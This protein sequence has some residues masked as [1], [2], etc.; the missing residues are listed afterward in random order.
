MRRIILAF[1]LVLTA[2]LP[3]RAQ[4]PN[5]ITTIAGGGVNG[6]NP[7]AAYLP[8]PFSTVRDSAGNTYISVPGLN[9]VY[10]VDATNKLTVFA[11]TGNSGFSGDG[12]A[13]TQ[14]QL[15]FPEGLAID[16]NN[17]LFIVDTNNNRIRRV[18]ATTGNITTVAGSEDPFN[19]NFGG[20]NGPATDARLNFPSGV[21]VDGNGDLFIT[22]TNNGAVRRVDGSTQIITTIAGGGAN[23]GCSG[24]AGNTA[25]FGDLIGIAV[26]GTGNV[27]VADAFLAIVC[28][29]DATTQNVSTYAGTLFNV[30]TPGAANGDGGPATSAQMDQPNGVAVD[31]LGNLFITDSGNP[32]IRKVD[33]SANHIISTVAGIGFI[34][35]TGGISLTEPGCGDGGLATSATFD[36]PRG[37]FVDS[38]NKIIVTDTFNMRVR[39][40]AAGVNPMITGFAGGGSGG[41]GGPAT[42]AIFGVAQTIAVDSNENVFALETNGV[43]LR[44]IAAAP[45]HDITTV[46]GVGVGGATIGPAPLNGDGGPATSASFVNPMAV[47]Q[48][49]AGN[50]YVA[51]PG[52]EVVRVI[53]NQASPITVATVTIQ[54]G[55]IAIIAGNGQRCGAPGNPVAKPL[56]GDN[57]SALS[58]SLLSPQGVAVD[59]SSGNVYISDTRLNTVRVVDKTTGTIST[60]AGTPGKACT[61]Y[62]T[63]CGDFGAPTSA[64]LNIPIGLATF[65]QGGAPVV[66]IA[67]AGD[68][69]IR[70]VNLNQNAIFPVMFNGLPS[71]GG[72]GGEGISASMEFPA[73][74]AVDDQGNIFVGGGSDNVV[75]R[76]DANAQTIITVAGD[77]DNLGGGF[78]GDGGPSTLAQI[79]NFG[80][81]VAKTAQGTH[82][83]FIADSGSNRIRKVNLAPV[84]ITEP[85]TGATL[86]FPPTLDLHASDPQ[87]IFFSNPGLDDL[88][89]SNVVV[90]NPNFVL[91]NTCIPVLAPEGS[92]ALQLM[93]SPAA[94]I[95]GTITGTLT[96]TT[97]DPGNPS[98]TYHLSGTATNN[99]ATLSVTLSPTAGG[100]VISDP[101]GIS[102]STSPAAV[103]GPVNFAANSTV[104]LVAFPNPGFVFTGWNTGNAPGANCPGTGSCAVPL[105]ASGGFSVVANF[106]PAGAGTFTVNVNLLGN[107]SGTVTSNPANTGNITCT[108]A[109][110]PCA[111][112]FPASTPSVTLNE[113]PTGAASV[114]AGWAGDTCFGA[115]VGPCNAGGGFAG[116]VTADAV[117]SGP[118]KPFAKGQVFLSTQDG[119]VF[120]I[121]P[122]TGKVVQVLTTASLSDGFGH[123]MTFDATGN[124]FIA[125]DN[126]PVLEFSNQAA[127]PTFFGNGGC[128]CDSEAHSVV[129]DPFGNVIVGEDFIGTDQQPTLL[130]FAPGAGPSGTPTGTFFPAYD[131]FSPA[132]W[133]EVLDSSDTIAYTQGTQTVKVFDLD[134]QVQHPDIAANLHGAFALRELPDT[135]ILVAD[136]D[137]I[138]RLDQSGNITQTYTVSGVPAVFQNLNLD[139]DGATF[140]TNDELTGIVYRINIG[141]GSVTN[142]AG[143]NTGLSSASLGPDFGVGGIA[144]FGQPASGGA[145]LAVTM[146]GPATI[147]AG[148]TAT[149]TIVAR[150]NGP[151][152]ATGVTMSAFIQN[153]AFTITNFSAPPGVSCQNQINVGTNDDTRFCTIG[154]MASGA[155]DTF[156][157][158]VQPTGTVT[159]TATMADSSPA[160]PNAT[161]NFAS[162]TTTITAPTLVSIAVTP[163]PATVAVGGTQQFTATGTFSDN[164]TQNLTS[165]AT[166][167]SGNTTIATINAAGLASGVKA[168]GPVT[169]TATSGT[170]SG[171]AQLT[172]TAPTLVSIA[173][174]PA[175][176]SIAKGKTQ[177][178]TAT[179]TFSDNSTQ[180]LTSTAT[181]ASATTSVATI[182][183]AGLATAV[184]TGT[185]TISA[186]QTGIS[187]ST[188]LTVTAPVLAS[189]AVTPANPSIA[190]GSTQQFT[191]T[192]TFSDNSTQNLTSTATWA[193]AT[194]TVATINAAG[195]ATAVNVGTS[196][197]SAT[198]SGISGSTVLTVSAN[199]LVTFSVT[200]T[201]SNGSVVDQTNSGTIQCSITNG[202]TAG[203]CSFA[204]TAGTAVSLKVTAGAGSDFNGWTAGPCVSSLANPCAFTIGSNTPNATATFVPS[205]IPVFTS[206]TLPNATAL[207]PFGADLQVRG[208]IQ[209][210]TFALTNGS[211]L[212]AGF[213]LNAAG[214]GG[215]AAGHISSDSPAAGSGT[216]SFGVTVTDSTTPTPQTVTATISLTVAAPASNTQAALLNGQYALFFETLQETSGDFEGVAGSLTFNTEG[217]V[218]GVLDINSSANG[219]TEGAAF[220]GSYTVGPDNRGTITLTQVGQSNSL[221]F[222]IAVGG[223]RNGVA[224]SAQVTEFDDDNANHTRGSGTLRLQDS[225]AFTAA[226]FAGTYTAQLTGQ[227]PQR[228]RSVYTGLYTFDANGNI[229]ALTL[230]VND[231]GVFTPGGPA[232]PGGT[233]TG[234][235]TNGR[236]V[237]VSPFAPF[238]D[239]IYQVSANQWIYQSLNPRSGGNDIAGGFA[240]R[241]TNP[242]SFSTAS[243]AG[244]DIMSVQG[245]SGEGAS[246]ALI[247]RAVASVVNQTPTL[248]LQ[249]DR[250]DGGNLLTNVTQTGTYTMAANGRAVLTIGNSTIV[251]FLATPDSG[252]IFATD[253]SGASGR[254]EPQIGGPF[255][256]ASV[257]G[258]YFYGTREIVSSTG[259][260]VFS[261][262]ATISNGTTINTTQDESDTGGDLFFGLQQ[263]FGYQV[264]SN[265]R[266]VLSDQQN[267][268]GYLT[269]PFALKVFDTGKSINPQIIDAQTLAAAAGI[270][271]PTTAQVNFPTVVQIGSTAQAQPITITN[272]GFGPLTF[273]GANL[274]NSPDFTAAGT[275]L[276]TAVVVIQPQSTCTIIVTFAPTVGAAVGQLLTEN[277]SVATDGGN[278]TI[279]ATG[280]AAS[281]AVIT[282]TPSATVSF[283]NQLVGTTSG[284]QGV[285]VTNTGTQAVTITT[286]TLNPAAGGNGTNPDGFTIISTDAECVNGVV[287]AATN[288]NCVLA[289]TF[290]PTAAGA[291]TSTIT[292][293]DALGSQVITLNGTGITPTIS[294]NPASL[295]F[296]TGPNTTSAAQTVTLT[297]AGAAPLHIANVSLGGPDV[298]DFAFVNGTTPCQK[299]TVVQP[300]GTCTIGLNFSAPSQATFNATVTIISDA[301]NG[302]QSIPVVGT[303]V[304]INITP[305]PGG[306]TTATVNPGG[307]AVFPLILSSTGL[308][309]TAT[310]TCSSPQASITCAVV[311]GSVPLT[312]NGI[313]HAAIVVNSFC[314]RMSPPASAPRGT[315]PAAPWLIALAGFALFASTAFTKKRSLRLVMPLAAILLIGVF[316]SSCGSPPKGPAGATPPGIYT[317]NITATVGQ[318]SSSVALTLIVN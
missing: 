105:P 208:G 251:I 244:P 10:K 41:D 227:T 99:V 287:L 292:L 111:F 298:A 17:N 46:A 170:I 129:I 81:A 191:A 62:P 240:L 147:T 8:L 209:P 258:P 277:I 47:A 32:K 237:I 279:T 176:P 214:T 221:T 67:D 245:T 91:V 25:G 113:T 65:V 252:F 66:Y 316:A 84:S 138:A 69:V 293:S 110:S 42:S 9:L 270:P 78:S 101:S 301:S 210:Y 291:V 297:N 177:Q 173:V 70:E 144:V 263:S 194:T 262:V 15:S 119:M 146:T 122:G 265:G 30:G 151:L 79:E 154:A 75:R 35:G 24:G 56:C 294:L 55:D 261:G 90:S 58:A 63:N 222:A 135:T 73:E 143:F 193:S 164:S 197:I 217:G 38:S 235:D 231:G 295:S 64:L 106:S 156:T 153:G 77:G 108:N 199:T 230:D 34:C 175:N 137:R 150:N 257:T 159:N 281:G 19:G 303:G 232:G 310:L 157:V 183:A 149:Y 14:A 72:D 260:G 268:V 168:G 80:L 89:L 271:S 37:V 31:A 20:D 185:S 206:T 142:G 114:F 247:G 275:C 181:W 238:H 83:L 239:V 233:Y 256:N 309:G 134:E 198:Q 249:V 269:S 88:I 160:D 85:A 107:G 6:T 48:D 86:T 189:I 187:G 16:K 267:S 115:G 87:F 155:S 179:G 130:Q 241:Q 128:P 98:F 132:V 60:F 40:I 229:T 223:V 21:A 166:W 190:K 302:D 174:T 102:C 215:V 94:G 71:F 266:I 314:T 248:T 318:A 264:A 5:T 283:G 162:V 182:N 82:D 52:E 4:V 304:V 299:G 27:F 163:N 116:S 200:L 117:F 272:I 3:A 186:T 216:T 184:N 140:W 202:Q 43:R 92:C 136:T 278:I 7:T 93:F 2:I 171:T 49:S 96:F 61:T 242:N 207:V 125:S 250:N 225:T 133:T 148:G 307:T 103:C 51:D 201:G 246:F 127:G 172:V 169:I 161:N 33:T 296:S 224:S 28:K 195:L 218:A 255:S 126:G 26:D 158:S 253:S 312:P 226:A 18:D 139:P 282:I 288:G 276:A 289:F 234:P 1:I 243:L 59:P 22:D 11:G 220:G 219:V 121:D 259:G 23:A 118:A 180:N 131:T 212:P 285:T 112:T 317:L 308:T 123:G 100:L 203:T 286:V 211:N 36:F 104:T 39:V 213:T 109:N 205:P 315:P 57:G 280:T 188:V 306:T 311:P 192:G 50:F 68:N 196:T 228:A 97:N 300:Q 152:A 305:P 76:M 204:Y 44:K 74:I 165:T 313:T 120:V 12:G 95:A 274:G 45:P 254:I 141:N 53:N 124:L 54:P 29:I 178:F 167:G 273:T 145:D 290:G 236:I 284:S 13:A